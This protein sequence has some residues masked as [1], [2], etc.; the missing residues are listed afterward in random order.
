MKV[1][2]WI[3]KT[4]DCIVVRWC[5]NGIVIKKNFHG[6]AKLFHFRSLSF[7]NRCQM[8]I[9]FLFVFF[10]PDATLAW[11]KIF[12]VTTSAT[13]F[14]LFCLRRESWRATDCSSSKRKWRWS[15]KA[16]KNNRNFIEIAVNLSV[17]PRQKSGRWKCSE[18][19]RDEINLP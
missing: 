17:D 8:K 19:E 2:C 9:V 11:V 12:N 4:F 7:T 6:C 18:I 5:W 3:R 10:N 14:V 15:E 16:K 13:F 1:T